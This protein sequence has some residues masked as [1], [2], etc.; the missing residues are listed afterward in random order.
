MIKKTYQPNVFK[1]EYIPVII[2]ILILGL[3][4]TAL[5]YT[6]M[7]KPKDKEKYYEEN[8]LPVDEVIVDVSNTICNKDIHEAIVKDASNLKV[9]Y[10]VIPDYYFGKAMELETDLNGDGELTETDTYG[11]ALKVVFEGLTDNIFVKLENDLDYEQKTIKNSDA[12]EGTYS[13]DQTENAYVRTYNVK[14]F[15]ARSECGEVLYREF[16][17]R[18]PRLNELR[19]LTMCEKFPDMDT[20]KSFVFVESEYELFK[21]YKNEVD[22]RLREEK[23]Q[24]KKEEEKQDSSINNI[25]KNKVVIIVAAVVLVVIVGCVVVIVMKR[26]K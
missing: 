11:P 26:R 24:K 2:A 22:T 6:I 5:V 7:Y 8:S 9:K 18:L 12:N 20:C 23:E 19:D 25:L 15:S 16:T 14:V 10:E 1:R 13:F 3:L 4:I 17:F 21:E